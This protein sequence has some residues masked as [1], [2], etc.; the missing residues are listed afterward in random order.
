M[1]DTHAHLQGLDG[2]PDAAIERAR[3]AGVTQIICIG[4][5]IESTNAAVGLAER[6]PGVFATAGVHPH[7]AASY[8]DDVECALDE[9]L[10]NPLVVAVGECGLDYFR[11][12]ATRADQLSAFRGQ[13]ALAE[14]HQ[15]PVVIHSREAADDTLAVLRNARCPV[16][17][18]CFSL[19]AELDEIVERRFACSFAGN[20]TYPAAADLADA[21]ARVPDDLILLETDSPYLTP[22]PHRGTPN[23]PERVLDTLAFVAHR[24][25]VEANVLAETVRRN[26]S[27]LFGLAEQ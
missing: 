11:N 21:A 23:R 2:G 1:I 25:G 13:V 16:V 9:L 4:T 15:K 19:P 26:A 22:V 24:R 14:Q 17:L 10:G 18:H 3:S 6:N 8:S 20:V 7:D 5:G 27:R 12:R